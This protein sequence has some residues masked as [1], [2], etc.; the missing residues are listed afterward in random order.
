MSHVPLGGRRWLAALKVRVR[1][2]VPSCRIIHNA[3]QT[4][5]QVTAPRAPCRLSLLETRP[6]AGLPDAKSLTS[7]G[8]HENEVHVFL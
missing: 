7:K 4:T 3:T 6:L 2:H 5:A 8:L 1:T